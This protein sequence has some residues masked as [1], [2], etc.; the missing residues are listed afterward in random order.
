[1]SCDLRVLENYCTGSLVR[2]VSI[3]IACYLSGTVLGCIYKRV[4]KI[5]MILYLSV[6]IYEIISRYQKRKKKKP[7]V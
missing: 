4:Q 7:R 1:M 6:S 2:I 5:D 3:F